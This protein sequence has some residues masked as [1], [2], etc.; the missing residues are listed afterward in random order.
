MWVPFLFAGGN[1]GRL[2]LTGR[3]SGL[4]CCLQGK[5]MFKSLGKA[6]PLFLAS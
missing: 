4:G 2:G 5:L 3:L 1:P 6:K